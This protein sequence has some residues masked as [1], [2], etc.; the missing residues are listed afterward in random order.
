VDSSDE[1]VRASV[2]STL[3]IIQLLAGINRTTL[4]KAT[5]WR[6]ATG[7]IGSRLI[8]GRGAAVASEAWL[9]FITAVF[10]LVFGRHDDGL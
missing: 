8:T 3:V 1:E 2:D 9:V 10:V 7:T 5:V 4:V 6:T